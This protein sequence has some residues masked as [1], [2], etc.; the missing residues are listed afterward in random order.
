[1]ILDQLLVE[2]PYVQIEVLVPVE[3]QNLCSE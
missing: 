1:M 2:V 3:A